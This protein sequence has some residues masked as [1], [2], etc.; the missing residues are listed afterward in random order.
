M[1]GTSAVVRRSRRK[2]A[3][4]RLSAGKVRTTRGRPLERVAFFA[5]VVWLAL[6]REHTAR[7]LRRVVWLMIN[8]S[9]P[10]LYLDRK[11]C[12]PDRSAG[13]AD[14]TFATCSA[15]S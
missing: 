12:K 9:G 15:R 7:L 4:A 2:S 1:V 13:G 5:I 14:L 8:L 6:P 10:M 3:I 11:R